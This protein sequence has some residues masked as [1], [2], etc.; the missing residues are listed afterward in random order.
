MRRDELGELLLAGEIQSL[1]S[2][3]NALEA[4][5]ARL[6]SLTPVAPLRSDPQLAAMVHP[7]R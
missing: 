2:P 1:E 4:V 3:G 6:H 5:G 7:R